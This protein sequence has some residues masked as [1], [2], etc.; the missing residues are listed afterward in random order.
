MNQEIRRTRLDSGKQRDDRSSVVL[1]RTRMGYRTRTRGEW[2]G[3]TEASR[4]EASC[5]TI[6]VSAVGDDVQIGS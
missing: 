4:E 6:A 3:N 1:Q 2:M 5:D